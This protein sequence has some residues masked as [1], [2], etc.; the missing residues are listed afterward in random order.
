MTRRGFTIVE[1]IITITIMGILLTL[2]VVNVGSTQLKARDDKRVASVQAIGS[3]LDGFYSNGRPAGGD[4]PTIKNQIGNPSFETNTVINTAYAFVTLAQTSAWASDGKYSMSIT[5]NN[6]SMD[7]FAAPGGD[8]GAMRMGMTAGK[9]YTL[10]A[11]LRVPAT[12]SGSFD[13]NRA[14]CIMAFWYVSG[15]YQNVKSCG[16][17]ANI[18]TYP[19][20]VTF[21]IPAGST[22]AF[23][24]L[25]HGGNLGT[26]PIYYDSIMLTEGTTRPDYSDGHGRLDMGWNTK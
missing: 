14:T 6:A 11:I 25:Y 26:G 17:S 13:G 20:S 3:Y 15:G 5:P 8:V 10:S 23:I 21:S 2:A 7:S 4:I 9:T 22:E 19:L 24:R 18:G 1:L 12:L 16:G